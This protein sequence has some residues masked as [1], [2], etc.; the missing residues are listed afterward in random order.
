MLE[1]AEITEKER[2]HNIKYEANLVHKYSIKVLLMR[3]AIE[4]YGLQKVIELEEPENDEGKKP[5]LLRKIP[6]E[7]RKI[8]CNRIKRYP[9]Y[10]DEQIAKTVFKECE[11]Y[12]L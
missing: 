11:F 2:K 7:E 9:K 12:P 3:I 10:T 1:L 6:L 4:E 5:V 8:L